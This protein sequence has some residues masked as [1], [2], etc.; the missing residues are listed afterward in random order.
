MYRLY[1]FP[2]S[3]N[4]YKIRLLLNQ[5]GIPFEPIKVDILQGEGKQPEFLSKNPKGKI[6]VLEIQPGIFLSESGSILLYLAEGTNFLPSDPLEKAK[7][8]EWLFFEQYSLG[9]NLSRPRY[10]ISVLKQP[11]KVAHMIDYWQI[12]GY[13][14]LD[15]MEN[16]LQNR[17]FFVGDR[18]TIADI[19][20]FAYTHVAEE[21]K[22]DLSKYPRIQT[23]IAKVQSQPKHITIQ[24]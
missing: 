7:V 8:T 17:S 18:Y 22:F 13:Q 12:L 21:G 3:A 15:V 24:D 5:L 20:L 9:A 11:E 4:S 14:A 23:W 1:H 19:A 10:Y 2:K 6:P 16:H